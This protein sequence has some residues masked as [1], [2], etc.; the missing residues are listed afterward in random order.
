MDKPSSRSDY[1]GMTGPRLQWRGGTLEVRAGRS[2]LRTTATLLRDDT[3]VAQGRGLGRVLV[4]V[5]AAEEPPPAVLVLAPLPGLVARTVLLV[6]R[7]REAGDSP[8]EDADA[9]VLDLVTAE[10]H[11]FDPE[12]G[13]VAAR[14]RA[15]EE[16]HPRLWAARH[17]AAA[18]VRV[19]AGLLGLLVLLQA[20]VRPLLR[21]VA[22]LVPDVDLPSIPLP[23]LD[24]PSIPWPDVDLPDVTL[25]GWLAAVL[26]TA[27]VWG[28]VLVGVGVAVAE[29]R[30]RRRRDALDG[31]GGGDDA[32][33]AHRRP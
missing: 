16:R 19:V 13:T 8:P 33:D 20:L 5:P 9:G 10:R 3:P 24:L 18:V 30:R 25:P 28:P 4:P 1:G 14:L 17:V 15:V 6:P 32:G 27:K 23:D 21:W 26:A 7:P 31:R 2:G 29:V 12:P 11:P 22:G